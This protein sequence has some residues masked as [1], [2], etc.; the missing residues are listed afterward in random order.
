VLYSLLHKYS[1]Q[2]DIIV[3]TSTFGR[4]NY[5]VQKIV[6][7]FV[8]KLPIRAYPKPDQTYNNLLDHVKSSFLNVINNQDLQFDEIVDILKI[9]RDSSRNPIFDITIDLQNFDKSNYQ[10]K[11]L[12]FLYNEFNSEAVRF[13]IAVQAYEYNSKLGLD[14]EYSDELFNESSI[15]NFGNRFLDI[16]RQVVQ[17]KGNIKLK[18]F[19]ILTKYQKPQSIHNELF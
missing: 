3:G 18:D 15:E 2:E 16:I 14:F 6:G 5:E 12:E 8:N 17:M 7:L 4:T 10:L 13:D 1:D 9:K 11:E 19:T